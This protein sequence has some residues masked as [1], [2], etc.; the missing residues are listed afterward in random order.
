MC[1]P[2]AISVIAFFVTLLSA[3]AG[4]AA[5][6][7]IT[8]GNDIRYTLTT[9]NVQVGDVITWQGGF[10]M[11]PMHFEAV[12]DGAVKPSDVTTGNTF[13]CT[14]E[15]PG[16]YAFYCNFHVSAGMARIYGAAGCIRRCIA[17][18]THVRC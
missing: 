14:V 7:T 18:H 15:I 9:L 11:H 17:W 16:N 1:A 3:R 13:S 2:R 12:P 4:N 5:I 10:S 8:F 6:H